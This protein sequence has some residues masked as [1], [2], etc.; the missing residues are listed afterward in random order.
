LLVEGQQLVVVHPP[1]QLDP[2]GG[3]MV[4]DPRLQRLALVALPGDDGAQ[5]RLLAM[6]LHERVDQ[7]V[8][9]FDGHQATHGDHQRRQRA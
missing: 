1:G 8:E 6:H 9:S 2:P 4:R 5:Q 3:A 7:H